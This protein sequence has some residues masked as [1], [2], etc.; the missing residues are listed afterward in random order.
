MWASEALMIGAEAGLHIFTGRVIKM[1]QLQ[2]LV[3][4]SVSH[5]CPLCWTRRHVM[6][7]GV[8]LLHTC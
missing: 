1:D 5:Q 2:P 6:Q 7:C 4:L 8:S 3:S